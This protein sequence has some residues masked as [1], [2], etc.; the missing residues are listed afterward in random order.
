MSAW[1]VWQGIK[2]RMETI[3]SLGT[4]ELGEPRGAIDK[5][6]IYALYLSFQTTLK[7]SPPA[8]N[9]RGKEHQ[10][11]LYLVVS[12][13]DQAAAETQLLQL[14]DIVTDAIEDDPHLGGRL[15]NGAAWIDKSVS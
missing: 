13:V 6:A 7:S 8:R 12:W 11:A 15:P 1:T 2:E 10:F 5:P 4:I 9:M 3:G 14:L